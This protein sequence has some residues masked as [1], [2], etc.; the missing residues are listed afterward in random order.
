[1]KEYRIRVKLAS[2]NYKQHAPK[3][4]VVPVAGKVTPIHDGSYVWI[5]KPVAP[6]LNW[7]CGTDVVWPVLKLEGHEFELLGT[8]YVCRHMIEIGD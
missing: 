1:M 3:V 4:A 7:T 5:G 2:M 6:H 8:P